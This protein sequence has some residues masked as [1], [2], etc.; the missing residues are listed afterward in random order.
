MIYNYCNKLLLL[1]IVF[2]NISVFYIYNIHI[3]PLVFYSRRWALSMNWFPKRSYIKQEQVVAHV[4]VVQYYN[5][6]CAW[7][8]AFYYYGA[9]SY[10][11]GQKILNVLK[12]KKTCFKMNQ[13]RSIR[14]NKACVSM[15]PG[16]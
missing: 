5:C 10:K 6:V 7:S 14:K 2:L 13:F 12:R 16:H 11:N 1:K 3:L 9:N 15:L 8:C 4:Q